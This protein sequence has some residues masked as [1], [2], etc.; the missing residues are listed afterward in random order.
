MEKHHHHGHDHH[1]HDHSERNLLLSTGL[2]LIITITEVIGGLI[3]N[4]LALLSDALHNLG[5]TTAVFIAYI[6]NRVSKKNY[7][8]TKTFGYKRIEIL[9]AV[10]N[11]V[12]LMAIILYLFVE[13]YQRF[14]NP[15]PIKSLVM[16]IVASVGL[17]AN[18]FS[19]MLLHAYSKKNINIRAA[20]LHLLGDTISSVAVIVGAVCIYFF[21]FYWIDPL[22][23]ILIGIY[24]LR[25]TFFVLKQSLEILMQN[26]PRGLDLNKVKKALENLDEIDNIHHVHAWN[27]TDQDIHFECHVD[28]KDDLRVSETDRV[29]AR[30]YKILNEKFNISHITVQYEFNCCD[31]KEMVHKRE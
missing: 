6:A 4:S 14:K 30:I 12:V 21:E 17:L 25:E 16:L 13:A 23:T 1:H 19:V 20:Y 24:L 31:S 7:T 22:I 18:L 8:N 27:L 5:D 3:S 9:A 11:A 10:F 28:L 2:N 26:T 15:E 29:K